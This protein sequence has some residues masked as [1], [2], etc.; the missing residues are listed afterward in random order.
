MK[1][2]TQ[3]NRSKTDFID[4]LNNESLIRTG[5]G[6]HAH[7]SPVALQHYYVSYQNADMSLRDYAQSLMKNRDH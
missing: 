5:Y 3:Q 4:A 7:Y 1:K 6:V 2:Q